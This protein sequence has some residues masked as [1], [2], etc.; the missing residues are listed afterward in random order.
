MIRFES[1]YTQGAV[2]EIIKKL[3]KINMEQN[4]GYSEDK[5]CE[6]ARKKIKIALNCKTC[7]VHFLV[8]GTQTNMVVISSA[9]RP[10]QGVICANTGHINVH[11]AGAIESTG[12]K[13][14]AIES[15]DGK[16]YPNQIEKYFIDYYND[17]TYDHMVQPSFVYV[18]QPTEN[19][20]LYTKG[21]LAEIY[22]I[23]KKYNSYFY[24]DGARF[25]YAL[26]A[27]ENLSLKDYP[28]LCDVF[29]IGG[30]K[31]GA[32]FG[33]AVVILND[34]LKKDFRYM[35]KQKGALLAKG[36]LLGV[37]FDAL[38]TDDLYIKISKHAVSLAMDIKKA[39]KEKNVSFLY[40]SYTN[41]QF[42]I[43]T[44]TQM[45]FLSKKYVFS[46]WA[47]IGEDFHAVRFC[48]SW[49]TNSDDVNKL[50]SDIKSM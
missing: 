25:G 30:T 35:I 3:S 46:Y 43:L 47:K 37:Q 40:D 34:N 31:V 19:G 28:K 44:S 6:E 32:L 38:F 9:L 2:P 1:D 16:I 20:T 22:E 50:I 21:E 15:T 36:W 26:A 41:Q 49:A 12:H 27:D 14:I 13:V 48:T 39:F 7:D 45:S 5:Y 10:H 4:A 42:P 29:Y 23:C 18:S 11:E 33:E 8:G 24:I 17:E